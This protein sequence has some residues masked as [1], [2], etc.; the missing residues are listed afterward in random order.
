MATTRQAGPGIGL[1]NAGLAGLNAQ[2]SILGGQTHIIPAGQFWV[3]PGPYCMVET[4]DPVSGLWRNQSSMGSNGQFVSSDGVNVRIANHTGTPVGA[5]V[6]NNGGNYTSAPTVTGNGTGGATWQAIVGGAVGNVTISTV[7]AG[8]NYPP[9]L[10]FDAP[11]VGGIQATGNVTIGTTGNI[12]AVTMIDNGAGYATAPKCYLIP[13][14]RELT[15]A[16]PGPTTA[17]V[18]TANLAGSGTV[19]AVICTNPG[20][21]VTTAPT[22]SFSGGGGASAA[23]TAVMCFGVTGFTVGAGGTGYGVANAF[24]IITSG[25]IVSGSAG[26]YANP[27]ISTNVFTPRQANIS[28][29]AGAGGN[30][31]ATSSVIND[32]G[33][34]QAVPT[35]IVLSAGG[36]VTVPGNVTMTVGAVTDHYQLQPF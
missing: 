3:T 15:A 20:A 11:P 31:T 10:V 1:S 33:L 16:T 5:F 24:A 21:P 25:G 35:G 13:D 14:P 8:Y 30:V 28:G 36:N 23:A 26:T 29:T 22:L 18:L 27:S 7:G 19:T 4:L 32:A 17:P 34:F 6:T 9:L 2:R 12:S